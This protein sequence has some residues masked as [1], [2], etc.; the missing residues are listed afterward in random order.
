[1]D[2]KLLKWRFGLTYH[3]IL[4]HTEYPSYATGS[5]WVDEPAL[6]WHQ[7]FLDLFF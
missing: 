1:M 2:A 6:Q 3:L 5:F 4:V 7:S